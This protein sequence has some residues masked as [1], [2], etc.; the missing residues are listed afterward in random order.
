MLP[1]EPFD[2]GPRVWLGGI[3]GGRLKFNGQSHIGK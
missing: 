3:Y 1:N 2:L